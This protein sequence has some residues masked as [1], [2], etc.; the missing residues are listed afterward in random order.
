MTINV[1][2]RKTKKAYV[3]TNQVSSEAVD[4]LLLSQDKFAVLWFVY[5]IQHWDLYNE[6]KS[7]SGVEIFSNIL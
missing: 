7:S 3:W 5:D 6:V 1:K 4:V 2:R